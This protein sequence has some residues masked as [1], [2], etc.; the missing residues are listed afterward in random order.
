MPNGLLKLTK[1]HVPQFALIYSGLSFDCGDFIGFVYCVLVKWNDR[2]N[3]ESGND[4]FVSM[5]K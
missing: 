4:C 5:F 1:V 2:I 3:D